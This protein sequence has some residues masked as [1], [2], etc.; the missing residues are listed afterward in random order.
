MFVGLVK[1]KAKRKSNARIT[2]EHCIR[3]AVS[4]YANLAA[5]AIPDPE[6]PTLNV[7]PRLLFNIDD[8]HLIKTSNSST[9]VIVTRERA[10]ERDIRQVEV[11]HDDT[12]SGSITV[13]TMIQPSGKAKIALVLGG[14]L[15][16]DCKQNFVHTELPVFSL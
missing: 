9:E 5:A 14:A 15:K 12:T 13:T 7:P 10:K 16:D 6:D 3:N 11:E 1:R 8:S 4:Q 2:A